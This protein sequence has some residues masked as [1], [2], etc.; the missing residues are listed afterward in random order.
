[1]RTI[2]LSTH[3]IYACIRA[4]GDAIAVACDEEDV[5]AAIDYCDALKA[6]A[7]QLDEEGP[8][9]ISERVA[10]WVDHFEQTPSDEVPMFLREQAS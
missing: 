8:H 5:E 1:M 10:P 4:L 2:R 3:L 6:L 9:N 7:Q